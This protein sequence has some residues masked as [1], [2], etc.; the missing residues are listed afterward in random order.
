MTKLLKTTNN[1][2]Q[3]K[4]EKKDIL[5]EKKALQ[6]K[7]NAA[8]VDLKRLQLAERIW[9]QNTSHLQ[10]IIKRKNESLFELETLNQDCAADNNNLREKIKSL[11]ESLAVSKKDYGIL[12]RK[13]DGEVVGL[14]RTINELKKV[15]MEHLER[16]KKL[17]EQMIKYSRHYISQLESLAAI[18]RSLD[19]ENERLL[20]ELKAARQPWFSFK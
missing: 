18:R 20:R 8:N 9:T 3:L 12:K 11:T 16:I 14:Q 17:D 19:Q 15:A 10:D 2:N 6:E 13:G 5:S 4:H 1:A 7:Y